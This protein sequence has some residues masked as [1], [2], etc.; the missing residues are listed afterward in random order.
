[1]SSSSATNTGMAAM[2][3]RGGSTS[4]QGGPGLDIGGKGTNVVINVNI[5]KATAEEAKRLAEMVK[6]ELE[7]DKL[8]SSMGRM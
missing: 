8:M 4:G 3:G 1:M 2:A 6:T 5:D 7:K